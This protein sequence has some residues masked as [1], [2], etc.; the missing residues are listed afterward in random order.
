[1]SFIKK[2][3][4]S[5]LLLFIVGFGAFLRFYHLDANPPAFNWDEVAFGY[6]AHSILQTGRDEYGKF[7]PIYWQ[8][9]D[10]YKRPVYSYI[11][12]V[13][14]AIFGYND[15]AVRFP[16]A[17]FGTLTIILIY[18]VTKE[19]TQNKKIS[20]ISSLLLAIVPWHIQ[21]S[22]PAFETTI[23]FF[24]TASGV[25]FFLKGKKR[26]TWWYPLS[27]LCLGLSAYSYLGQRVVAP[28]L[29]IGMVLIFSRSFF[30]VKKQLIK[31][32]HIIP[33]LI[34]IFITFFF[35]FS[36]Y[37]D[38]LKPEGAIRY[39]ATNIFDNSPEYQHR[40]EQVVL[41]G[42]LKINLTRRLFHDS[43]K[44]TSLGLITRGYLT[45]FSPDFLFFDLGQTHHHAPSVG[46][47]YLWMLPFLLIGIYQLFKK[48]AFQNIAVIFLWL[49]IPPVAAS[50]T[51]QIPH[52]MRAGEMIIPFQ[53]IIA[54]GIYEFFVLIKKINGYIFAF[55]LLLVSGIG[56][57]SLWYLS[58]QYHIHFPYER[59]DQWAYGRKEAVMYAEKNKHKY[60]KVIIS[61]Y[62]EYSYIFFLYYSKYDPK[63]YLAEGGT[64][65]GSWEEEGNK[66][67]KYEFHK[68]NFLEEHTKGK[69]L[70]I[71][72]PD[73]FP[74]GT[75]IDQIIYYL[76]G[77]PAIYI[78][79]T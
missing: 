51:W 27:T 43:V 38:S 60:D 37:R 31:K 57:V 76:D 65:S 12:V 44:L 40:A 34:S 45:H 24:L 25:L 17:F 26:N 54:V 21:F 71:G 14:E 39:K 59:S 32:G 77:K 29:L 67:D 9:L 5:I 46:L 33:V 61:T 16:S 7:L 8:S 41:D 36:I 19:L 6:N 48:Y 79:G 49:L 28:L 74:K 11:T 56:I 30:S 62:L 63:K 66:F 18:F 64:H 55:L 68:F 1:M 22:R 78:K 10:D 73:E 35:F 53:I 13:S 4:F 72:K 75:K 58:H 23:G 50:V 15:F 3:F 42:K 20:L 69:I 2:Y 47:L 52:A 70:Y